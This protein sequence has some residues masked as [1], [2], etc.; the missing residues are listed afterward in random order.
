[1]RPAIADATATTGGPPTAGTGPEAR[2]ALTPARQATRSAGASRRKEVRMVPRIAG[3]L[4]DRRAP[5]APRRPLASA[6]PG[7]LSP[8]S[9]APPGPPPS[10]LGGGVAGAVRGGRRGGPQGGGGGGGPPAPGGGR[11]RLAPRLIAPTSR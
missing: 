11:R 10:R 8:L 2:C 1:M 6:A 4:P 7:A 9:V 3:T 5:A